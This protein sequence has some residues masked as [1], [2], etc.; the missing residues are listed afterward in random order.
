MLLT[1]SISGGCGATSG[2]LASAKDEPVPLPA[3]V[4]P[5]LKD[6]PKWATTPCTRLKALPRKE[7][8]QKE[9][10]DKWDGDVDVLN[11]CQAKHTM[12]LKFYRQRDQALRE[13]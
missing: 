10:E 11:D 5:V 9:I 6:P 8:T 13:K 1:A 3:T 2:L 7:M 12:M 4:K